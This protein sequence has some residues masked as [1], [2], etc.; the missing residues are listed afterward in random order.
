[1]ELYSDDGGPTLYGNVRYNAYEGGDISMRE[2]AEEIREDLEDGKM[3][4]M[5]K[6]QRWTV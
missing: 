1:L 5:F 4:V 3:P 2:V 6:R